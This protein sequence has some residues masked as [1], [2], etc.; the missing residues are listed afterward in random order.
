MQQYYRLGVLD[1]CSEKWNA[2]LD[3]LNLKTK[4]SSEVEVFLK[5][6]MG[7]FCISI[8]LNS[9]FFVLVCT[10]TLRIIDG[11]VFLLN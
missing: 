7:M 11:L 9:E 3:C 8:E 10:H 4:R 5:L 2:L 6:L 1:N